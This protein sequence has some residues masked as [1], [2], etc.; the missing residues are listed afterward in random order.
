MNTITIRKRLNSDVLKLGKQ[1]KSLLGKNVEIV[2]RE[3]D[4]PKPAKREWHFFGSI[5]L[6]GKLD[7]VNIRD[8]A[9]D[10]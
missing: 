3:I 6:K 5:D 4:D 7:S 1:V 10:D 8:F 2:I 9:H